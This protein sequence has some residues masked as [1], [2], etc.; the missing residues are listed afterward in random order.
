MMELDV[1]DTAGNAV[2]KVQLNDA[3]FNSEMKPHLVHEVVVMQLANRRQGT[4]ATKTKGLVNR[5]GKK[6][7]R[8]KG[9]G[10]ARAGSSASPLWRGGGTIFGPTPRD[11]SYKVPKKIRQAALRSA[12]TSKVKEEQFL[13]L[14]SL[15]FPQPKT[16]EAA[17]ILR[18]LRPSGKIL[19]LLPEPNR[20][21]ELSLRN[22]PDVK[23]LPLAGLN[24]YDLL[25]HDVVICLKGALPKIEE[26][27]SR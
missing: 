18:K 13:V 16:R 14:D 24:V 27:L 9:T 26:A 11:Y 17:A 8:Q 25:Y 2:E 21:I 10:R 3:I 23:P 5:S 6:P 19:L 4:A 12:L 22:I 1:L 15:E 7:W 20:N